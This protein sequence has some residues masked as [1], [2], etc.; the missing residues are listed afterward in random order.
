MTGPVRT[1]RGR[2]TDAATAGTGRPEAAPVMTENPAMAAGIIADS[3]D[4]GSDGMKMNMK[5]G[6]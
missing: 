6:R 2:S 1:V 4:P 5:T 3:R